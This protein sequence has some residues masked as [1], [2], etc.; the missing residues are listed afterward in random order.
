MPASGQVAAGEGQDLGSG[1]ALAG[2]R[3]LPVL[4]GVLLAAAD[5][6]RE[7]AAEVTGEVGEIPP[8]DAA[9][10]LGDDT[11]RRRLGQR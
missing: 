8:A 3:D 6:E 11:A 9:A 5:V 2:S 4:V 7:R 1:H 10:V